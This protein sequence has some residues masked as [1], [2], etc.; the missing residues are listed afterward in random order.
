MRSGRAGGA[1]SSRPPSGRERLYGAAR[2]A[3]GRG[4]KALA[5]FRAGLTEQQDGAL[6]AIL[7]ELTDRANDADARDDS[8]PQQEA[9]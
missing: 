4:T 8:D 2:E 9:A 1:A 3:A 6:D 5:E 7:R